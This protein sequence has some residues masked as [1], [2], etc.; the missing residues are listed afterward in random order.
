[1]GFWG[2]GVSGYRCSLCDCDIGGAHSTTCSPEDGQCQC[3]PNM[4]GRRCSEP[5][6]GHFLPP[7]DYFLYEAELA[8]PLQGSPPPPPP[9]TPPPPPPPPPTPSSSSPLLSPL[10][11]PRCEQIYREQGYDFKVRDGVVVLVRRTRRAGRR[12]RQNLPLEPG[13][14]LQIIPRQR[15]GGQ[16]ITWTGLGFVR[17]LEG[18]GLRFTV[19]N[20]PSSMD[21]QLVIRYEPESPSDWLAS[22]SAIAGSPGNGGCR[23]D[24][25]G[26]RTL[27]LPG[28]SRGGVLDSPLCLNADARY[29]V[30]VVF[31]KQPDGSNSN[32]I[33]IDSMGLIPSIESVQDFCSQTDLDSFRRFRCIGLAAELDPQE[34]LP[35]VCEGLVK[36]MSARIHRGA[37]RCRCNAAG[38]LSPSC[39]KLGGVCECKP[40]V[41]GRCCDACAPLTF[42]FGPDGCQ[43]CECHAA[44]SDPLCEQ[45]RGQCSCRRDIAGRRCDRCRK[46]F[47]GFPLCRPCECNGLSDKCEEDTGECVECREDAAGPHCD[48]DV[49]G[50]FYGDPV[51][52]RPCEP[53]L[54]PGVQGSGRFFATSC[55]PDPESLSLSCDCSSGHSG[56]HCDRCSPGFYG[57]L[58]S[59]GAGCER[60][61]CNNNIAPE[62]RDACDAVTGVCQRCLHGTGGEHCQHCRAGYYGDALL[63]D[64]KECTCE[65]RGT[66]VTQCP[67]GSPCVCEPQMGQCPCRGGVQ[68][69]LCDQCEDEY[70]NLGGGA[71]CQ[72]CSCDTANAFSNTCNK[73]TGQCPCH[74]EFGGRQCDVCGENHFGNPDLQCFSCDCNL[75]GTEPPSC[76]PETGEC[77]CREGVSGIFC[78][79]CSSG[80]SAFPLC[81]PCHTCRALWAQQ[82]EDVQRAAH[83]MRRF[84]PFH[85]NQRPTGGRPEQRML[86][87]QAALHLLGNLTGD[88][89]SRV[90]QVEHLRARVGKLQDGLDQNRILMDTSALLHTELDNIGLEFKKLLNNLK[91]KTFTDQSAGDMEDEEGLLDEIQNQHRAFILDEKK[92]RKAITAVEE[93]MDTRQ[94]V[95][96]RLSTCSRSDLEPLERRVL[97]LRVG[98]LNRRVC[99]ASGPDGCSG[100]GGALCAL[101]LGGRKCGG[102]NC[103]GAFP[104]SQEASETAEGVKDK[105]STLPKAL[106]DA[107][108]KIDD[109]TREA[110]LTR[111]KAKDLQDQINSNIDSLQREK[112]ITKALLQ[113][114]RD[115]LIDEKVPP[116]DIEKMAR[117]VLDIKLPRSPYQTRSLIN[118]INNLLFNTSS[119]QDSLE[120]LEDHARTA[121]DLLKDARELK[122]RTETV[123]LSGISRDLYEAERAQDKANDQLHTS[124]GDRDRTRDQIQDMRDKLEDMETKLMSRRPED[125]QDQIPAL[126]EKTDQNRETAGGAGE[127]AE[128][129]VKQ[130]ADTQPQLD[131]A[132]SLFEVLQ[133]RN[134]NRKGGDAERLKNLLQEAEDMKTLLQDKLNQI[135]GIEQ[136][137][138]E[139]LRNRS[140][141][142]GQVSDLLLAADALR[143]EIFSR[144]EGYAICTS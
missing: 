114:V 108:T 18:A 132:L 51:S 134:R 105:L 128:S 85:D 83:T 86:Q 119:L 82:V 84:I 43:P 92:V 99:G 75:E 57:D 38:S 140:D 142:A 72:P 87:L 61:L 96:R 131:R 23:G 100:C 15:A 137:M 79:E 10:V 124:T 41:I 13:H 94:E 73:V 80:Y 11:L 29:L 8:A 93:S 126:K 33:L 32:G 64:C 117:A 16:L 65:R 24:P 113:R 19:D 46:G 14:A 62:E 56:P 109:A 66:E 122:E 139:L 115:Y 116:E 111:R 39:S 118:D 101:D 138:E 4:G 35:E 1:A 67:E 74:A 78:D 95:K 110:Q 3:L 58:R 76:D 28:N 60:C 68:G 97:D 27:I 102:P 2:L 45:V 144:A 12:R 98:D 55:R 59:P 89:P 36:S 9:S 71:G 22:V 129:A 6:A 7:L 5:T 130:S 103:D 123:D 30:D 40:N 50:G 135:Q 42:G 90:E 69:I 133:L 17:V 120:N 21:Y 106:Q 70:W 127:T 112:D 20:L 141:R 37:V 49:Y 81:A 88:A 48:R 52:R 25:K 91:D 34:G 125:L 53:C 47:W 54:C 63:Q 26:S 121:H 143:R 107:N 44:G 136:R 31:N 77:L 104:V